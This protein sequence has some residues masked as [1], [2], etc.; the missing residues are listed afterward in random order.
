MDITRLANATDSDQITHLQIT[1]WKLSHPEIA[2]LLDAED[3]QSQ[4]AHAITDQGARGRVLICERDG[5][6]VGVAAVEFDQDI[7]HLSLIEVAPDLRR[8]LI[9]SRLLNAAAD[10]AHKSGCMRLNC[11]LNEDQHDGRLFLES[12]GWGISGASRTLGTVTDDPDRTVVAHQIEL[13]TSLE[14]E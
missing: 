1:N 13:T 9:G 11:W 10:L 4:W 7:G 8:T 2:H 3:V 5:I 12:T 14:T 6:L